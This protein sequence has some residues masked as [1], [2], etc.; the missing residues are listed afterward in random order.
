MS[1]LERCT[2]HR[3]T[4]RVTRSWADD[5]E[6]RRIP[7]ICY[8]LTISVN[9][10]HAIKTR[11]YWKTKSKTKFSSLVLSNVTVPVLSGWAV[12]GSSEAGGHPGQHASPATWP[13]QHNMWRR[14]S[15][16]KAVGDINK[17]LL[18]NYNNIVTVSNIQIWYS[19]RLWD[20]NSKKQSS[21]WLLLHI[22]IRY[23]LLHPL[24]VLTVN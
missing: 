2:P 11:E 3:Y 20:Q 24:Q 23:I 4:A 17:Y 8:F 6:L 7:W 18:N 16:W 1:S 21:Y 14:H 22:A 9:G 13:G 10:L 19:W 12:S 5:I 15:R